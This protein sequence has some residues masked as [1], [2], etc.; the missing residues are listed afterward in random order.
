[1]T[2]GG[3]ILVRYCPDMKKK[4]NFIFN[5]LKKN[6]VQFTLFSEFTLQVE[7]LMVHDPMRVSLLL[8]KTTLF[9]RPSGR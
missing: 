6:L 7:K 1:M 3:F 8:W 9:L 4:Q 5:Y 2:I